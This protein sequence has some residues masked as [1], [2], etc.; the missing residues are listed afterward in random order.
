MFDW[1]TQTFCLND[2]MSNYYADFS[3]TSLTGR[4]AQGVAILFLEKEGYHY[5]GNFKTVWEYITNS[6]IQGQTPDFM[7]ANAQNQ[8]VPVETK[9]S[10]VTPGKSPS[11]GVILRKAL[12]QLQAWNGR[13]LYNQP[14]NKSFAVGTFLREYSDRVREDSAIVFV[15]PKPET[16]E[17]SV[18][19]PS[20]YIHRANYA[21]WL[22]LMGYGDSANRLR[23]LKLTDKTQEYPVPCVEIEGHDYAVSVISISPNFSQ[24]IFDEQ[25]WP[26]FEGY[27]DFP[28]VLEE[29]GL[30]VEIIGIDLGILNSISSALTDEEKPD[31]FDL[32][33]PL[34]RQK[35][36]YKVEGGRFY[37]S[38][39]SDGSLLG[40]L[41]LTSEFFNF[42]KVEFIPL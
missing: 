20:D 40:E 22:A 9:G 14:I 32:I 39:F 27:F 6:Q 4:I 1:G 35:D 30:R 36:E 25:F 37:G 42:K 31:L 41:R 19:F 13:V 12:N 10:F 24:D 3:R 34:K 7:F 16:S 2:G 8:W 29:Y 18:E 28:D 23:K 21:S 26:N 38:V 33:E 5:V 17:D 15:D 11:F